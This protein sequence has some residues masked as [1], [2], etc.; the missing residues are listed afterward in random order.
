MRELDARKR[1]GRRTKGF[2]GEH[3][4]AA[5]ALSLDGVLFE[6]SIWQ[7]AAASLSINA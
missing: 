7:L 1:N 4:R 6:N 2:E 5:D 3:G